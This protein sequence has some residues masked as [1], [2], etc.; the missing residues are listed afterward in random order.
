[1]INSEISNSPKAMQRLINK[2]GRK[3]RRIVDSESGQ[4]SKAKSITLNTCAICLDDIAIEK[5]VRLDSCNHRYC[6]DCI[7]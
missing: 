4:S 3:R 2:G 5:E 1:M 6:G 7:T